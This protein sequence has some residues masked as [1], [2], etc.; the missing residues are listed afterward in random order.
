MFTVTQ[1]HVWKAP[2]DYP[3]TLRCTF[4][5]DA[6]RA[7]AALWHLSALMLPVFD[8]LRVRLEGPNVNGAGD[9]WLSARL[10]VRL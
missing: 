6:S 4:N 10:E 9:A 3:R 1:I 8:S 7:L 2:K 5:R